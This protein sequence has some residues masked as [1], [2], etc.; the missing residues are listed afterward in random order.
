MTKRIWLSIWVTL[1]IFV[2]F[3][4][5]PTIS[6]AQG[7]SH[8][9]LVLTAEGPV[10]PAMV[11]YLRRGIR[12]A[13]EQGAEA[14]IFQLNTPGGSIDLMEHMV[15]DI[16]ASEVPVI[17]YIWPR[18][19]IAGS[20]GTVIT[21]AGHLS[22]M[23][24]ETAIGA[25]S[26]VGGQGEDLGKTLEEKVKETLKAQVRSLM[27]ERRPT[28][29]IALAEDTINNAKAATV[30]EAHEIGMIDFLAVD[31]DDLLEQINGVTV[32]T[33]S[34]ERAL[35][36]VNT[37]VTELPPSFIEQLLATLTNPNIVFILLAIGVQATLIELGSPGG[38]VAGF[39]GAVCITL[40]AY[41][42][43]V[44]GVNWLGLIFLA[45]SFV[46]F[47]LDIKAP[48]H[49]A[50]TAAGVGSFIVGALV[51]FNSPGTPEFQLV[52]VP[53]VVISSL[54]IGGSFALVLIFALRAQD[55]PIGIG[56]ES[57]IGRIGTVRHELAPAGIVQL[58][59]EQWS[60]ELVDRNSN[61]P[62]GEKVEVIMTEG[63]RLYVRKAK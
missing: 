60:A 39:I 47:V 15:Q 41:G 11:E 23:A 6:Q 14:L 5:Q 40:A 21:M 8:N 20:A 19:A 36:T 18:G 2:L 16:R 45:I 61:L 50:L 37:I 24:P 43:G 35:H 9:V 22:A 29:A 25:A 28:E 33:N 53:L 42:L 44:L 1:G 55:T 4:P 46:L 52:S 54:V 30:Y 62:K 51:L 26:P 49:G 57:M 17:I 58:G 63:I 56:Q 12:M 32:E 3:Q 59:G 34:G 27:E 10:T 13:E 31:L 7:E 38:W 48:T